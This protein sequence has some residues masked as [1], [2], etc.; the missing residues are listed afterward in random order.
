MNF[1]IIKNYRI[2]CIKVKIIYFLL[3]KILGHQVNSIEV[4]KVISQFCL[5]KLI[6]TC[7]RHPKKIAILLTIRN[8]KLLEIMSGKFSKFSSRML[9]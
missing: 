5:N 6:S 2:I 3:T 9:I 1:K 4:L 8:R 7:L